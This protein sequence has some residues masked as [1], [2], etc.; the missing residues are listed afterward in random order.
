MCSQ[1]V[2]KKHF[3]GIHLGTLPWWKFSIQKFLKRN[4]ILLYFWGQC[5][6]T[7]I[8]NDLFTLFRRSLVHTLICGCIYFSVEQS[9]DQSR[10]IGSG[11]RLSRKFDEHFLVWE[12]E[13]YYVWLNV[14]FKRSGFQEFGGRKKLLNK[15]LVS[16]NLFNLPN[17]QFA[18][19]IHE[20]LSTFPCRKALF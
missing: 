16:L 11:G 14:L 12:V 17:V 18:A 19:I 1:Y 3:W 9:I 15:N 6:K 20:N 13:N 10:Q 5:W 2:A 4:Q 8:A 7:F